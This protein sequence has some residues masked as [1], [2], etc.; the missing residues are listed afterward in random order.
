MRPAARRLAVVQ[1]ERRAA[2]VVRV[3]TD[4]QTRNEEGS[5]KTQL[6]RL[7]QH[8]EY[9]IGIGEAWAEIEVYELKAISGK[10]SMLSPEIQRLM[11]DI[12]SGR[13]NTVMFTALSRLCRS[14]RDFLQF[15]EVL[16]QNDANFVSLKEDYDTTTAHGRL[17]MTII[18][19]LAEFEREQ[20][21]ERTKDAFAARADRGLWNGNY[22]Y[23][24]DL[25][26]QRKGY[27]LPNQDESFVVNFAFS[28]YLRLGSIKGTMDSM[29]AHG[30]RS[31]GYKSRR[32]VVHQPRPFALNN[33]QHMLKNRGYVGEKVTP[34]RRVVPAVWPAIVERD[35]FDKV[36][37]LLK[38]NGR[39][40]HSQAKPIRHVHILNNGLLFCGKCT[41]AMVGRSG[42]GR[43]GATYF[44]YV[45]PTS[46]CGTRA[47]SSLVEDAVIERIGILASSPESVASLVAEANKALER[48]R[49]EPEARIRA[50]ERGLK[51]VD[52]DA[53]VLA[54]SLGAAT[55]DAVQI[56]NAQLAS[57]GGTREALENTL[58]SARLEVQRIDDGAVDPT[59]VRNGLANFGRAFAHLQP[60]E[61]RELT[62]LVL[63]RATLHESELVLE[64]YGGS[65]STFAGQKESEP[66]AGFAE[67]PHWLP[68]VDS[69]HEH[70]G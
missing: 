23:G 43:G 42:T 38:L 51:S 8:V 59:F 66:I 14:V 69:N 2:L 49:T 11:A 27:L 12:A 4:M 36:Q 50:A 46:E 52:R 5:L 58:S 15:V 29:N 24:Y 34:D 54:R 45:C 16:D 60:Y 21:S 26:A 22:L 19:A 10:D 47:T 62:R 63:K 48:R 31:R 17:I 32:E 37:A 1:P 35:V 6:Q 67:A 30:F 44:Y 70:R 7:R 3:S 55:G 65:L 64:L 13:V 53:A 39:A 25:D 56:V 57:L 33:V 61:Q 68:D 40:N 28:E 20:T 9:K 18:M 41:K